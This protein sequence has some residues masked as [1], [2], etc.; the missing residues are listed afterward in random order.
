MRPTPQQKRELEKRL[1]I[2]ILLLEATPTRL[3]ELADLNGVNGKMRRTVLISTLYNK[4]IATY[5]P[6]ISTPTTTNNRIET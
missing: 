4:M 2:I 5:E 1:D 6:T 3:K